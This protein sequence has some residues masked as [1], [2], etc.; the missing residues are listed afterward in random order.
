MSPSAPSRGGCV[1]GDE[2]GGDFDGAAH[3]ASLFA[4]KPGLRGEILGRRKAAAGGP[5]LRRTGCGHVGRL[6]LGVGLGLWQGLR[7]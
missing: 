6:V 3:V 5:R 4:V 2:C 7:R 1:G